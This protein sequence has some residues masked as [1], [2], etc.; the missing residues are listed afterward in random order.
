MF[1]TW[2]VIVG[3]DFVSGVFEKFRPIW[4]ENWWSA[5][6]KAVKTTVPHTLLSYASLWMKLLISDCPPN[7]F[8]SYPSARIFFNSSWIIGFSGGAR[9]IYDYGFVAVIEE[10]DHF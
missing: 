9:A 2:K 3:C 1:S 10:S 7:S 8:P 4:Y 5:S 6:E